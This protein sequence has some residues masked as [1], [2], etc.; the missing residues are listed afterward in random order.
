MAPRLSAPLGIC[1]GQ[2]P[3]VTLLSIRPSHCIRSKQQRPSLVSHDGCNAAHISCTVTHHVFSAA[4]PNHQQT[5][6]TH[7]PI[8][9]SSSCPTR[10]GPSCGQLLF[11]TK[12]ILGTIIYSVHESYRTA[13]TDLLPSMPHLA[14]DV[15]RCSSRAVRTVCHPFDAVG[16]CGAGLTTAELRGGTIGGITGA[17]PVHPE[18]QMRKFYGAQQQ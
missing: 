9:M 18:Q 12:K 1:I 13:N 8:S 4:R 3:N 14:C 2:C 5:L 7:E 11:R 15:P 10:L 16:G 17:H 6:S